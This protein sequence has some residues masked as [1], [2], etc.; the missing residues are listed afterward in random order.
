MLKIRKSKWTH[1]IFVLFLQFFKGLKIFQIEKLKG[2]I[3]IRN[4]ENL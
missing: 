3:S 4:Q 1:D 2:K